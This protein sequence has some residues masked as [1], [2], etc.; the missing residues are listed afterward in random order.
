MSLFGGLLIGSVAQAARLPIK[1]YTTAD[2]LARDHVNHILCDSKGYVWL[3]T[4]EGLSRYDGYEFRN[5][6]IANGL[7]HPSVSDIVEAGE[8]RYWV[9][10][11][12]GLCLFD[13]VRGGKFTVY[14]PEE[15]GGGRYVGTIRR[16]RFGW[17]WCATSA[18]LFKMQ[19]YGDRMQFEKVDF[20]IPPLAWEGPRV[21]DIVE[22]RSGRLWI[23]AEGELHRYDSKTRT[24]ARIPG[25]APP[26]NGVGV[27]FADRDGRIWVGTTNGVYVLALD[28]GG[29][30]RLERSWEAAQLPLMSHI[31]SLFQSSDGTIWVGAFRGLTSF[32]PDADA[33]GFDLRS[34]TKANGLSDVGISSLAEDRDGNLWV[35]TEV[36]GVMKISQ[37][38]FVSYDQADGLGGT[39]IDAIFEDL[40]GDLCVYTTHLDNITISRWTGSGFRVTRP[41]LP[42]GITY[43]GWGTHQLA[44]QDHTGEWWIP[45]GQGL[46]RYPRASSPDALATMPPKAVMTSRDGLPVD[47]IFRLHEDPTG[48]IW[49]GTIGPTAGN[50]SC[51]HRES[52]KLQRYVEGVPPEAPTAFREDRAGNLWIGF[53]LRGLARRR[54]E[55]FDRFTEK[56]GA[57]AGFIFDLFLDSQGRMWVASHRGGVARIDEPGAQ[58]PSFTRYT[59]REGLSSNDVRCITEDRY[60]RIYVGTGRGVDRLDPRTGRIRHYTT[61][62]GLASSEQQVAYRD[63]NGVLWFGTMAG[64]SRLDPAPDPPCTPPPILIQGIRISGEALPISELGESEVAALELGPTQNRIQLDFIGLGFA[65]GEVLRY[66]WRLDGADPDWGSPSPSRSVNYARLA[67]G[68]YRFLVRAVSS[69]GSTSTSPASVSFVVLPPI[70]RRWWFISVAVVFSAS[71]LLTA[72]HL[73]VKRLLELERVRT[74]I[75]TDLHDDIGASLSQITILSEVLRKKTGDQEIEF[76]GPLDQ[77]AKTSRELMEAMSDI[78]WAINPRRDRLSDLVIRMRRFASDMLAS[79]GIALRMD[80]PDSSHGD[81]ALGAD[82][83]RHVLLIFKEGVNNIVR[84]SKCGEVSIAMRIHGGWLSLLLRDDG[85]GFD[86]GSTTGHGQG[87][88]SMRARASSMGGCLDIRSRPGG[89]TEIELRVPVAGRPHRWDLGGAQ[90]RPQ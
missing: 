76:S 33:G 52:G 10:T 74:R 34:Y 82:L 13:A 36:G 72:N 27:L 16:S 19:Q 68:R 58:H 35:G 64:L 7:P 69:D 86:L 49:I 38:G 63:R 70:W 73:R 6:G 12:G 8:G 80:V 28:A 18:G 54:G 4:T 11:G 75:A 5:Y 47:E 21:L 23:A 44:L 83:R 78:V 79:R 60:G 45:T 42:R 25:F 57:P 3:C 2:G 53:Y 50:L 51:W 48:D 46:C 29:E 9:A 37:S 55:R 90:A 17:L 20:G 31:T 81:T 30:A 24:A 62:D 84:H 32:R 88:A 65:A 39:R 61:A 87:L 89:G 56:E 59:T 71:A 77:I 41:N 67:P 26:S 85:T 15:T 43:T 66:Q 14:R 22:D 1:T 40:Q